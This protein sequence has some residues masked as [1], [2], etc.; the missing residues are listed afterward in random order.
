MYFYV[1]KWQNLVLE[2]PTVVGITTEVVLSPFTR[3]SYG[4]DR[5]C[6]L[7][8]LPVVQDAAITST[9]A[10]SGAVNGDQV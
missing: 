5:T 10:S 6:Q 1:S 4:V 2:T 7:N 8:S 9:H 3:C